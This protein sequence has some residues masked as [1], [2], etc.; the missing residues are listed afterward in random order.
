MKSFFYKKQRMALM[1]G[2]SHNTKQ[3]KLMVTVERK[4]KPTSVSV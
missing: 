2:H 1:D 4:D 3:G